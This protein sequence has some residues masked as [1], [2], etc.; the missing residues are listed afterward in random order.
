MRKIGI[1]LADESADIVERLCQLTGMN[2][3][4]LV[5]LLLRK[6]GKELELSVGTPATSAPPQHQT[7]APVPAPS[8]NASAEFYELKTVAFY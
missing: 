1:T 5:G 7:N 3:A 6:F 8:G 2:S 4:S